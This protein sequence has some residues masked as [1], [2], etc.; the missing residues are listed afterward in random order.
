MDALYD[1][2][3]AFA[4]ACAAL[5]AIMFILSMLMVDLLNLAAFRQISRV[6]KMFL[7]AVLRQDMAW[8]DTNTS[9]NFA[10]RIN[11][12]VFFLSLH[13]YVISQIEDNKKLWNHHDKRFRSAIGKYFIS[14]SDIKS[15]KKKSLIIKYN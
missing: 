14:I 15:L 1:D 4:A 12:W 13:R 9:T 8:Y 2:S 3:A 5:S 6:R 10:S 7:K 11:E